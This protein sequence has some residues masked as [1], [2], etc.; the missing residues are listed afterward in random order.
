MGQAHGL[1]CTRRSAGVQQS[2][3]LRDTRQREARGQGDG[4]GGQVVPGAHPCRDLA[5][6]LAALGAGSGH[7]QPQG[8]AAAQ[9][10]MTGQIH[11][12]H[13]QA[14]QA[15][16]LQGAHRRHKT[17]EGLLPGDDDAPAVDVELLA[18]LGG[19][20]QR[21]VLGHDRPD[22]PGR[23]GHDHVLRTVGKNDPDDVPAPDP[24]APQG[25]RGPRHLGLQ[26]G[27]GRRGAQEVQGHPVREVPGGVA[28]HA[29][30]G[31]AHRRDRGGHPR[32]TVDGLKG[33]IA[34]GVRVGR[35]RGAARERGYRRA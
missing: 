4:G 5:A 16:R 20:R 19:G 24:Q 11:R 30:Q 9:R 8:Q 27:V 3:R 21:V 6:Y 15:R 2:R 32:L 31:L 33:L 12:V 26:L 35:R 14:P 7:R 10:K 22:A 29:R 34:R 28:Q 13:A 18:Q 23:V 1:G 17:L 25:L